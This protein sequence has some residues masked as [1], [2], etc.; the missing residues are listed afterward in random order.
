[1]NH[2]DTTY[3]LVKIYALL[4]T[5]DHAMKVNAGRL[6]AEDGRLIRSGKN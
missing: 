6:G 2:Q 3:I 5:G 4:L 1:M